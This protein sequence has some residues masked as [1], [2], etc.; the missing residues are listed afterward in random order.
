MASLI[1][2]H[3]PQF[4]S[5][6][7]VFGELEMVDSKSFE[8]RYVVLFFYPADFSYICTT[9]LLSFEE[10]LDEF[11]LI[12]CAF[13]GISCDSDMIHLHWTETPIER[14]GLGPI[15]FPLVSDATGKISRQFGIWDESS[16]CASRASFIV[17]G[18]GI[19]RHVAVFDIAVGR[20]VTEH[21][22]IIKALKFSDKFKEQCR[23]EWRPKDNTKLI[24]GK[25]VEKLSGESRDKPSG[26]SDSGNGERGKENE[27]TKGE[28]SEEEE[29]EEEET[30]EEVDETDSRSEEGESISD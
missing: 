30:E 21:L 5:K 27:R 29:T 25:K 15:R 8:G 26:S 7:V 28:E 18:E 22:R 12:D 1:G 6:A 19:V 4:E 14:E 17:D 2:K 9:E 3:F 16:G 11:L 24:K 10:R 13:V 20:N 23:L